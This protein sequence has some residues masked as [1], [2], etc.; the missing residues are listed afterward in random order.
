MRGI[1]ILLYMNNNLLTFTKLS[2]LNSLKFPMRY[3]TPLRTSALS[4]R[5]LTRSH[6][7]VPPISSTLAPV[8]PR[9]PTRLPI[10]PP[11]RPPPSFHNHLSKVPSLY[12]STNPYQEPSPIHPPIQ[13]P[14]RSPFSPLGPF[15]L[16]PS[17]PSPIVSP[18]IASVGA[19]ERRR[20]SRLHDAT[21]ITSPSPAP[22]ANRSPQRGCPDCKK[23]NS[24]SNNPG[25]CQRV[26]MLLPAKWCHHQVSRKFSVVNVA[27]ICILFLRFPFHP[28]PAL[29]RPL[30]SSSDGLVGISQ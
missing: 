24:K 16:T 2:Q 21:S 13:T 23:A 3:T 18:I 8:A 4:S 1:N 10:R 27:F 30:C 25:P 9:T 5:G 26:G 14:I 29:G 11:T 6:T 7:N 20:E 12:S 28:F 22:R 17:D 19:R 15:P